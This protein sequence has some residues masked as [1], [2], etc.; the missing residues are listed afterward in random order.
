MYLEYLTI[1]VKD[2]S[3][4]HLI[5]SLKN[6]LLFNYLEEGQRILNFE[7]EIYDNKELF[8]AAESFLNEHDIKDENPFFNEFNINDYALQIDFNIPSSSQA[9]IILE[10]MVYHLGQL[11][12]KEL[13][14]EC[15]VM[16]DNMRVPVGLFKEGALTT[17]FSS[18]SK[19]FFTTRQWKPQ[20]G[21]E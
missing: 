3:Y 16:F 1:G 17:L 18:Y 8:L 21:V 10:P 20:L 9:K 19:E 15:L 11:L 5:S 2:S 7:I 14:N 6:I 13:N 4:K 12:S